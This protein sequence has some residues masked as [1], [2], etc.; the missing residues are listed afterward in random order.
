MN[1]FEV[2]K[3]LMMRNHITY[4]DLSKRLGYKSKST[5]YTILGHKH[6]YVDTWRKFLDIFGY[7]IVIRKKI[8]PKTEIVVTADGLPS[9]LRFHDMSL[10]F[11]KILGDKQSE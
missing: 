5:A 10:N 7:E 8:S 6:I 11:D 4:E 9:P 3:H 2:I 1:E